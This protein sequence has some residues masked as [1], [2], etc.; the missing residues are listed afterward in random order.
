MNMSKSFRD[1]ARTAMSGEVLE[2]LTVFLPRSVVRALRE[3]VPPGQRRAFIARALET[4]LNKTREPA[5]S[6]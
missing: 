4:A 5:Q 2:Q 6:Q 3:Q 1:Q